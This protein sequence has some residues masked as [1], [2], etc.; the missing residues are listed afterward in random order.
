MSLSVKDV[1]YLKRTPRKYNGVSDFQGKYQ[2]LALCYGMEQHRKRLV[3][4]VA[5][6]VT[7]NS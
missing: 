6:A 1:R 5:I 4:G 7:L 2:P 3:Q